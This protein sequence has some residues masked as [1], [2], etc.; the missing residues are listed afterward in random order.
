MMMNSIMAPEASSMSLRKRFQS[1]FKPAL[2]GAAL[3]LAAPPAV[4]AD[5]PPW[6]PT[7]GYRA[8]QENAPKFKAS[9][10]QYDEA[11]YAQSTQ[12][13][14][15]TQNTCNREAVSV[16]VVGQSAGQVSAAVAGSVDGTIVGNGVGAQMDQI[17]QA[18]TGQAL[19]RAE[20]YQAVGWTNP[21]TGAH[22]NVALT[23]IFEM[24]SRYCRGWVTRII[25]NNQIE[26]AQGQACRDPD[27]I[28]RRAS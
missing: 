11:A 21:S 6:A 5:P 16:L 27:G 18:C 9:S 23:G 10:R 13:Y 14:G 25:M 1:V 20:D 3:I 19:E 17:D 28:W 12:A 22:Y 4:L 26:T 7:Y 24:D 8:N 2:I 15:I